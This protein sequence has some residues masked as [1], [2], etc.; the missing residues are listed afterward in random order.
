MKKSAVIFDLDNTIYSVYSIGEELFAP[1]FQLIHQDGNYGSDMEQ[2]KDD[3]MRRP[4]QVVASDYGF[5]EELK[6]QG[7]TLLREMR[8]E[9]KIEPFEDYTFVRSLPLNKFLVTT[10][11]LKLQQSKVE[12]MKL[13]QDFTEIHIVDPSTSER[14]KKDVF[15]DILKRHG[16]AKEQVL[17]VGDDLD[18]EIKAAQ[19]LGIEAVLYDNFHRHR[20]QTPIP[21]I[22]NFRELT[23]VYSS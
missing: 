13:E 14:T 5:S 12:G 17:V 18:S 1:L 3:S 19:D 20:E 2:I 7:L 10:G 22:S 23:Q 16:Y 15:A 11:F 4:F 8:Y 21:R 9:G 6:A